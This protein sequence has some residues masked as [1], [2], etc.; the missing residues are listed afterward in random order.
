MQGRGRGPP[1]P[2]SAA[3]E[4]RLSRSRRT[5]A[6]HLGPRYV[7]QGRGSNYRTGSPGL[8]IDAQ[9]AVLYCHPQEEI[10]G[11]GGRGDDEGTTAHNLRPPSGSS[12]TTVREYQSGTPCF[13]E[14]GSPRVIRVDPRFRHGL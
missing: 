9:H 7:N 4:Q 14:T 6:A 5:R 2:A 8:G 3:R 11:Y 12:C 13:V 10:A 1:F